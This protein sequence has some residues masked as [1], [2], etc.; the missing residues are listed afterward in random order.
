MEKDGCSIWMY[1]TVAKVDE[2]IHEGCVVLGRPGCVW[3]YRP[4][5]G[6]KLPRVLVIGRTDFIPLSVLVSSNPALKPCVDVQ[7]GSSVTLGHSFVPPHDHPSLRPPR[8]ATSRADQNL[9]HL[10]C[11]GFIH[12]TDRSHL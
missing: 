1:N 12:P 2:I 3:M 7:R 10:D 6:Q 11:Y 8:T 5:N 4:S 9:I